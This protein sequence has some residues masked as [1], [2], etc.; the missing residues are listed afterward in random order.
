MTS[1]NE[2]EEVSTHYILVLDTSSSMKDP[3]NTLLEA[4]QDFFKLTQQKQ[5][6]NYFSVIRF[7]RNANAIF[8]KKTS[9]TSLSE[10]LEPIKTINTKEFVPATVYDTAIQEIKNIMDQEI[11]TATA[12]TPVMPFV[13]VFLSDGKSEPEPK[14]FSAL[15]E[16]TY[17][18]YIKMFYTVGLSRK[19]AVDNDF[20][21]L[22]EMAKIMQEKGCFIPIEN[23]QLVETYKEIA[24]I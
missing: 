24:T 12:S 21:M 10:L 8:T 17:F 2:I 13:T 4:V 1:N 15:R 9:S 18:Q 20:K 5:C 11:K 3:W 22:K 19:T 14:T 7:D 23:I 6:K 16:E